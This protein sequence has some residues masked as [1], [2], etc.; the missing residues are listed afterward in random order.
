MLQDSTA[1]HT[2]PLAVAS[3]MVRQLVVERRR[4]RVT[5]APRPSALVVGNP[6]I[7]DP[8]FPSMPGAAAEAA[9]VG[10][11]LRRHGYDVA[12]LTGGAASPLAVMS[13]LHA[14]PWRILHLAAHGVFRFAPGARG[15]PVTGLVLDHGTFLTPAEAAQMRH[16]PELVF[17]NCCHLGRTDAGTAP[18]PP[19]HRLAANLAVEFIEMGAR[20]VVA[21]GWA[22]QD[23]A[24]RTFATTF[25]DALLSG[26]PFGEAV[27]LAR[28]CTFERHP[29]ANT[30]GAYQCYGDPSFSLADTKGEQPPEPPAA[31]IEVAAFAIEIAR[32]AAQSGTPGKPGLLADL[33]AALSSMPQA[34]WHVPALR[35]AVAEALASLGEFEDA[36][37][38]YDALLVAD[39]AQVPLS[40]LE[41]LVALK[42]R[43]AA[44]LGA[45]GD[46]GG[47]ALRL[48]GEA[49]RL[50]D[51]LTAI[52]DTATRRALRDAAAGSAPDGCESGAGGITSAC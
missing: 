48:R 50:L 19:F 46:D 18:S 39:P 16:V 43:W 31:P 9:A 2:L 52:G 12:A 13:A 30:W 20:A 51:H 26:T 23:E 40:A 1:G 27:A 28:R 5:R 17:V 44:S 15:A 29:G 25:Y 7:E 24:A 33:R 4:E 11:L 42:L 45:R 6:E 47:L 35:G 34:W 8:R 41:Q 37:G 21:A 10:T 32:Q 22:V 38:H 14:S 3:G 36:A 49:G